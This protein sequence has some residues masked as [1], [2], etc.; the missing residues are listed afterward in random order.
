MKLRVQVDVH[1]QEDGT[2]V[3]AA[4]KKGRGGTPVKA[5]VKKG[6]GGT[7]VKGTCVSIFCWTLNVC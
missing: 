7:P 4:V 6:G 5:A 3:K 1:V 2:P